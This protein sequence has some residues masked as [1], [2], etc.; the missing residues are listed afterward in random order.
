MIM[1]PSQ[2]YY[3]KYLSMQ[4]R[5]HE[6]LRLL[7]DLFC[8]LKSFPFFWSKLGILKKKGYTSIIIL[9][10]YEEGENEIQF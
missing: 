8:F 3:S 4:I 6:S 1:L 9:E 2:I 10:M 5:C 7:N